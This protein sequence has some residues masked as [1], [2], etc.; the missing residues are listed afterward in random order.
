M[1]NSR[2]IFQGN[3]AGSSSRILEMLTSSKAVTASYAISAEK[4]S[5]DS[6]GGLGEPVYFRD[7]K[8]V[9]DVKTREVVDWVVNNSG[10]LLL[11]GSISTGDASY[12]VSGS[13][14]LRI[15]PV[16]GEFVFETMDKSIQE[17]IDEGYAYT[18]VTE[19]VTYITLRTDCPYS[20]EEIRD[21]NDILSNKV[22]IDGAI[23]NTLRWS[24]ALPAGWSAVEVAKAYTDSEAFS[25]IQPKPN[26]FWG[27][28]MGDVDEISLKFAGGAS[29]YIIEEGLFNPRGYESS[30]TATPKTVNVTIDGDYSSILQTF[31]TRMYGTHVLNF[32]YG[33]IDCHDVAGLF[34]YCVNLEEINTSGTWHLNGIRNITNMF[35][36]CNALKEIPLGCSTLPR[37]HEYNTITC[38]RDQWRGMSSY[39]QTFYNCH[40]LERILPTLDWIAN[41]TDDM[42]NNTF[43][44]CVKLHDVRIKNLNNCDWDFTSNSCYLP[45]LDIDSVNYLLQNV[46]S[47]VSVVWGIRNGKTIEGFVEGGDKATDRISTLYWTDNNETAYTVTDTGIP[48]TV[49]D[50]GGFTITLNAERQSEID[51]SLI[52]EVE[53]KGWTVEFKSVA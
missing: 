52:A 37:D 48:V 29:W 31:F 53:S 49:T 35:N 17:L 2:G 41:T 43:T 34:E 30:R 8:P 44:G 45:F 22:Q 14:R 42:K 33:T 51:P 32:S 47:N 39:E 21:F 7:G 5:T 46:A 36:S 20:Q 38:R 15:D 1:S 12:L 10:S 6:V 16:A 3:V 26:L 9:A 23:A 24:E 25:D 19:S 13:Y 28:D 18:T 40:E 11:S 4:L 50:V 27:I